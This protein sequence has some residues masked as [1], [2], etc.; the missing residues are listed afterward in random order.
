MSLVIVSGVEIGRRTAEAVLEAGFLV[1]LLCGYEASMADASGYASM[2]DLGKRY[3]VPVHSTRDI[4]TPQSLTTLAAAKPDVVLVLG[5]SRLI[6][7]EFLSIPRHGVVGTHPTRLPR[8]RGRAPI[9]WTLIHGLTETALSVFYIDG[10]VDSGDIVAQ[11]PFSVGFEDT[12]RTLYE[13]IA[14]LQEKTILALL[15]SLLDGTAAR[16]PQD[17]SQATYWP[18]RTPADG[19]MDWDKSAFDQYNWVRGLTHPYP[20]AFTFCQ[21]RKLT[22]WAACYLDNEPDP[23]PP[24][25]ILSV[26]PIHAVVVCSPGHIA[27]TAVA[28]EGDQERTPEEAGLAPGQRFELEEP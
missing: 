20:G 17:N 25:T 21:G 19:V 22:V 11:P 12:A 28:W 2:D 5:W 1:S 10:G 24:G 18:K 3:S 16:T 4:N 7:P 13:K 6:G 23:A 8:H 27:L 9:P 26:E 15:P 14:E